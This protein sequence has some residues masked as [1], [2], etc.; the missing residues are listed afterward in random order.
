MT[1]AERDRAINYL[2]G[3]RQNL[4]N[5]TERLSPTQLAFKPALDRW[6]IAECLEHIIVVENFVH[7]RIVDALRQ[8]ADSSKRSAY[9]GKDEALIERIV[10]RV[11]RAQAPEVVH[12]GG[13]WS[14]DRLLPEFRVARGRSLDLVAK[15]DAPVRQY[16]FPH[17]AFG[18][19][20]CY[21][22]MLVI[23]AHGDRHRVQ[24]EEVAASAGF[25]VAAQGKATP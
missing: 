17:P 12:P 15:T 7:D 6:S 1:P 8:P 10:G 23:G 4:L 3:T 25:P 18:P 19:L 2:H 24:I 20:D 9:E 11:E 5:G 22:W 16:L 13:R 21:Q 14:H